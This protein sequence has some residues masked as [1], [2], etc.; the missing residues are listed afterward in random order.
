M[1]KI[2][3]SLLAV[4]LSF[5]LS[6]Q[7]WDV[8]E[9]NHG[10]ITKITAT[11]CGPCGGWG[12]DGF[13]DLIENHNEDHICMALY[14]SSTSDYYSTDADAIAQEIGFGGYPNFA[15]NGEDVG[16]AHASVGGV[17]SAFESAPVQ[18]GIGYEIVDVKEDEITIAVKAEFFEEME[19]TFVVAG[20][21]IEDHVIGYQNGQGDSADH[22]QVFRGSFTE[23]SNDFII[24]EEGASSGETFSKTLTI[25]RGAE[26]NLDN[27]EIAVAL[28]VQDESNPQDLIY[29]NGSK[30][31]QSGELAEGGGSG[32]SGGSGGEGEEE[33]NNGNPSDW[34]VGIDDEE[35]SSIEMYPN[36]ANDLLNIEMASASDFQV[37]ISDL[38]GKVVLTEVVVSNSRTTLDVSSLPK[39]LYM[40]KVSTD[41]D[42]HLERVIVK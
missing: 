33:E 3:L 24:T 13:A 16:T 8:P 42:S 40:V 17:I 39:G 20:Y 10:L 19:G 7:S 38:L 6:A 37:Q 14:A 36:P 31:P 28:W 27:S 9:E 26:W 18:A 23:E 11:W 35:S 1:K 25:T 5:G 12:W 29:I 30:V 4:G 21:F 32:G 2:Y 41:T 34:T 22:H 15:G